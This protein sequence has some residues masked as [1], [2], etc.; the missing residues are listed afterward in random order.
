MP[1]HTTTETLLHRAGG[2]AA[3]AVA[4][5]DAMGGETEEIVFAAAMLLAYVARDTHT[6]MAHVWEAARGMTFQF[7]DLS[8]QGGESDEPK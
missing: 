6:P 7:Y 3:A 5:A 1:I 2:I 8:M 4:A